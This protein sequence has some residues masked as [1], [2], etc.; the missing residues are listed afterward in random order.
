MESELENHGIFEQ[1]KDWQL[2]NDGQVTY[3][4]CHHWP[5]QIIIIVSMSN[6]ADMPGSCES[7]AVGAGKES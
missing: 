4:T 7:E 2:S 1:L 6:S 3:C 5:S